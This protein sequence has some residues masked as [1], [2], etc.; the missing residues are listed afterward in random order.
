M[1][2]SKISRDLDWQPRQTLASGL[3]STVKWY[4][5]NPGWIEAIRNQGDYQGWLEKNYEERE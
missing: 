2:I 4:L 5:E 1:D 3:L